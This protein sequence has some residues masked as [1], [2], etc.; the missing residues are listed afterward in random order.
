MKPC[1]NR[2]LVCCGALV[3]AGLLSSCI[4]SNRNETHFGVWRTF[5]REAF[6]TTELPPPINVVTVVLDWTP[7]AIIQYLHVGREWRHTFTVGVL[8]TEVS[9]ERNND[10]SERHGKRYAKQDI[11][12]IGGTNLVTRH[13]QHTSLNMQATTSLAFA[14][15][16]GLSFSSYLWVVLIAGHGGALR[17]IAAS[18]VLP[19]LSAWS[20]LVSIS[21]YICPALKPFD[22]SSL[23]AQ[24]YETRAQ[25]SEQL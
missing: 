8:G 22:S 15:L 13:L 14:L 10:G 2:A 1:I 7:A 6:F 21:I 19:A 25:T 5:S 18:L 16:A 12:S 11:C 9:K 20:L 4:D 23:P 24:L 17:K 3:V